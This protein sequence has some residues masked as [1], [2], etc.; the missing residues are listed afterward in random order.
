[1]YSSLV[2]HP[3]YALKSIMV[4]NKPQ[5]T[6]QHHND[7][8]NARMTLLSLILGGQNTASAAPVSVGSN[9]IVGTQAVDQAPVPPTLYPT[10]LST[11]GTDKPPHESNNT[12]TFLHVHATSVHGR[13][14]L[15]D[16]QNA[17]SQAI[18]GQDHGYSVSFVNFVLRGC[19]EDELEHDRAK[20]R[21]VGRRS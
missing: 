7:G 3:L 14:T 17:Y 6:G 4:A 18:T 5:S 20:G 1:M 15:D 8:S 19:I 16:I 12:T 21:R 10:H 13:Y 9:S 11:G 2:S